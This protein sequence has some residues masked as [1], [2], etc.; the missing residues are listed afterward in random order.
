MSFTEGGFV[1][2]LENL[3]ETQDSIVSISQWVLFH[4][5]H[6]SEICEIWKKFTLSAPSNKILSLLYLCNDVVQQSKHKQKLEILKVFATVIPQVI[7]EVMVKLDDRIKPKVERLVNVWETRSVF[8][9]N[10][11]NA[12]KQAL[13]AT[14]KPSKEPKLPTKP[15]NLP[16]IPL[17]PTPVTTPS[18][19]SEIVS[20]ILE[21]NNLFVHL[22]QLTDKSQT[23]LNEV[24]IQSMNYLPHDPSTTDLP[25]TNEHITKLNDLEDLCKTTLDTFDQVKKSKKKIVDTLKQL[26]NSLENGLNAD[27]YKKSIVKDKLSKL[28]Q[29]RNQLQGQDPEDFSGYSYSD[30]TSAN[31]EDEFVAPTYDSDSDTESPKFTSQ[32]VEPLPKKPKKGRKRR[33]S[34]AFSDNVEIKEYD[35][36]NLEVIK[37]IKS[38]DDFSDLSEFER[39]DHEDT[40]HETNEGNTPSVLDLLSKL[41]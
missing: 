26:V 18:T 11:L 20:E 34:V 33:K 38:D 12:M 21:V 1:K 28:H 15:L 9:A 23:T 39:T 22:N 13:T 30:Y 2:K 40:D 35:R 17:P 25:E 10:D 32:S 19:P 29:T 4:H 7:S 6:I 3:Q 27:E 5:R 8:T 37:I 36:D 16:A 24:G 14:P 31:S 41:T